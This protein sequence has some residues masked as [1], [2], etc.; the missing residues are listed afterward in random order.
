M[1][2]LKVGLKIF[3]V[4]TFLTGVVYP[5]LIWGYSLAFV[6]EKA[7]GSYIQNQE[8]IVGSRLIGQK[9]TQARYF[10]GRPSA[11]DYN[12]AASGGSN[13][14]PTSADLKKAV[15]ER[16][17]DGIPAD[18]IFASGSGLDPHISLDAALFQA[19]KVAKARDLDISTVRNLIKEL[20]ES[21]QFGILG[22]TRI[23]VLHLNVAL[24]RLTK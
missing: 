19:G 7:L 23:N 8:K 5:L 4:M 15:D 9:F 17:Q 12:P 14:G 16:L 10:Y 3:L 18:L 1:K 24:D 22:E 6:K 20:T 11:V 13:L 2:N 21:P